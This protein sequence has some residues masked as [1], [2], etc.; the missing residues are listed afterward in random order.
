MPRSFINRFARVYVDTLKEEDMILIGH[1]LLQK[2]LHDYYGLDN[3]C[4]N[5]NAYQ[6]IVDKMVRFVVQLDELQ[7]RGRAKNVNS[8]E[9]NLRDVFR[10]CDLMLVNQ[11]YEKMERIMNSVNDWHPEMFVS[12]LFLQRMRDSLQR[13]RVLDLFNATFSMHFTP[14]AFPSFHITDTTIQIGNAISLPHQLY[15]VLI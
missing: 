1:Q 9:F 4:V 12:M 3:A 8:F 13:Q 7:N 10:W 14:A 5:E 15:T 6:A 11:E 2:K